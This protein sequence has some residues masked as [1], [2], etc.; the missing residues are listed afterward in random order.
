MATD[1]VSVIANQIMPAIE[2]KGENN[3]DQK[4]NQT[5]IDTISVITI[6]DVSASEEPREKSEDVE[7]ETTLKSISKVIFFTI[8]IVFLSALNVVPWTTIGRTNSIIYQ[9]YWMELLLPLATFWI[10]EAGTH[11]LNRLHTSITF[12]SYPRILVSFLSIPN[13]LTNCRMLLLL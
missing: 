7:G 4:Q 9:R 1:F 13:I 6:D 10:Q 12:C 5:E 11:M 3:G 2:R 8:A